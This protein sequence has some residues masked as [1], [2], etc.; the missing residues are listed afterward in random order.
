[1]SK[2]FYAV[3]FS[4]LAG[5]A[6]V[7]IFFSQK[8]D[9][10]YNFDLDSVMHTETGEKVKGKVLFVTDTLLFWSHKHLGLSDINAVIVVSRSPAGILMGRP[11]THG[12]L[13]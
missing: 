10:T 11:G 1:M 3:G 7:I 12:L 5:V 13:N 6:H 9:G 8:N 4:L 2:H